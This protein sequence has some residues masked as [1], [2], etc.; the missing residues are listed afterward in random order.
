M[1]FAGHSKLVKLYFKIGTWT[2]TMFAV[3]QCRWTYFKLK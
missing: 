1:V 2:T 3:T